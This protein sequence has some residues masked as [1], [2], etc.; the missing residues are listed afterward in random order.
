[1]KKDRNFSM[2]NQGFMSVT[3]Q[4]GMNMGFPYPG[5]NMQN[6]MN[7]SMGMNSNMSMGPMGINS[8]MGANLNSGTNIDFTGYSDLNQ[9]NDRVSRLERQIRKIDARLNR[10]E[11][12]YPDAQPIPYQYNN[13]NDNGFQIV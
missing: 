2:S 9:I 6:M 4:M 1:M 11:S 3:P 7:P 13:N 5:M 10:L 8:N 12:P